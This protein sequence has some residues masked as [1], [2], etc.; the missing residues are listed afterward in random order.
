MVD[1]PFKD[2]VWLPK[3]QMRTTDTVMGSFF[4]FLFYIGVSPINSVVIDSGGQQRDS[5]IHIH[6]SIPPQL[7]SHP[8]CYITAQE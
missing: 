4:N 2:E 6:V 3:K 8:G 5:A 1:K 7:P